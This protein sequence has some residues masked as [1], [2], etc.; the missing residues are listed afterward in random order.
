M[1][2][3][4]NVYAAAI[5]AERFAGSRI[6]AFSTGN[7]Y[8]L[9]PVAGLG[10]NEDDPVGPIG[11]YAA[12][13]LGRERMFEYESA[14]HGTPVVVLRLNYAVEPRYGVVRDLADR[15][16]RGEPIDLALAF[17]NIIWQRDANAIALRALRLAATPARILNL[18]GPKVRIRDIAVRLGEALG[19]A[20]EVIIPV[21]LYS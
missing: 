12:S 9:T 21:P 13:A 11:E 17:V 3:A 20:P 16:V 15:I 14:R 8:P 18:T 6:V 19:R 1:T 7:V 5:A 4:T 10:P 2:W